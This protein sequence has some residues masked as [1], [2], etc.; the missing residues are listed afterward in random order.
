MNILVTGAN[1]QLGSELAAIA[2]QYRQHHF[3]FTDIDTLDIGN[4][5]A[6]EHFVNKNSVQAIINCAAYTAVDKA[7]S[8]EANA[9]RINAL[10]V[11]SLGEVAALC[12]MLM[13]HV[14]TD[15]VFD[16]TNHKPYK[17]TDAVCPT[18]VY[19]RTKLLGEQ[20]LQKVHPEA[21][22][23]RTSW[24]YSSYG[25]NFVKTM[26][27]LGE[28]R[29]L[30][31]VVGDQVGTPT[32]A[33][34]LAA[35]LMHIVNTEKRVAGIY[36]FSNEGVCSWYDFTVVIHKIKGIACKVSPIDSDAY[37]V[38]TPRPHYSVLNKGKIKQT[39]GIDI[40]HWQEALARC[41]EKL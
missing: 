14:S 41:L 28:E 21:I 17:E 18:N 23:V 26:M 34:D 10:A 35:A 27:R 39:Y 24:L 6:I 38:R 29:D 12:N 30:L 7:E 37:P 9:H 1:G 31:G 11:Q 4:K 15:Y 16:G 5:E 19:G 25:S 22:V 40:A 2:P 33:A 20:L 32:Y 13:L 3:L 8:D 36:H